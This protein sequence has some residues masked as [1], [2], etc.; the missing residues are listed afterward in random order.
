MVRSTRGRSTTPGVIVYDEA[1]RVQRRLAVRQV[2]ALAIDATD[3]TVLL[4][5]LGL[6]PVTDSRVAAGDARN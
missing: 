4:D 5:V 6:D 1:T 2:C 3:A